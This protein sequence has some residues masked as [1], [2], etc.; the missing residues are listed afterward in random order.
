MKQLI[1]TTA[2]L[3][4]MA[5][6]ALA[7][8]RGHEPVKQQITNNY[9]GKGG[10]AS[11]RSNASAKAHASARS[12]SRSNSSATGGNATATGGSASSYSGG[13]TVNF[14]D[15]LQAPGFA[16]GG[17]SSTSPCQGYTELGG[18]FPGGGFAFGTSRSIKW[19][20]D[21]WLA[22]TYG[23]HFGSKVARQYMIESDAKLKKIV[24][25]K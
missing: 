18:S 15:R 13:N 7:T 17:G 14:K 16:L 22:E 1:I 12:S 3:A 5:G 24:T 2:V 20:R 19:C 25:G 10:S 6:P 11:S 4:L 9:G 8:Q 21:V 23:K